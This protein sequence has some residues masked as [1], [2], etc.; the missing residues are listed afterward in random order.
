MISLVCVHK[1]IRSW[2]KKGDAES[3]EEWTG[4]TDSGGKD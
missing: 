1:T 4:Q 3:E 2:L